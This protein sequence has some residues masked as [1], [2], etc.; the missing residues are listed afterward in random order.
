MSLINQ[1]ITKYKYEG[2][3]EL[4]AATIMAVL[5][6]KAPFLTV[7][8]L[9]KLSWFIAKL[10]TMGCASLGLVIMNVG[11]EKVDE[12]VDNNKFDGTWEDGNKMR[13]AILRSGRELTDEEIRAINEPV[14]DA[15]RKFGRIGR[16]RQRRNS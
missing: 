2:I 13:D 12:I 11:V 15:F 4:G 5:K 8:L 9:G 7:G 16:M 1:P 3:G 6:F 14:K 10:F